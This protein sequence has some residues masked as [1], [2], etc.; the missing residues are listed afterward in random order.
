M[1][2]AIETLLCCSLAISAITSVVWDIDHCAQV[3][4]EHFLAGEARGAGVF[5][6]RG[7][8]FKKGHFFVKK[9]LPTKANF[10]SHPAI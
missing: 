10:G 7:E 5:F 2:I 9:A 8:K 3:A 6:A 4:P 1:Q